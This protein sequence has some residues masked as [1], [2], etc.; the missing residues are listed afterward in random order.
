MSVPEIPAEKRRE[1]HAENIHPVLSDIKVHTVVS[2]ELDCDH[3]A[4]MKVLNFVIAFN[5]RFICSDKNP[6]NLI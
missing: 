4:S 3:A 5:A 6:S 2:A 1:S